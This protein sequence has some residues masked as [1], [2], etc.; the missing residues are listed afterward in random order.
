LAGQSSPRDLPAAS[1]SFCLFLRFFL[2]MNLTDEIDRGR[3]LFTG[4]L[5]YKDIQ[6]IQPVSRLLLRFQVV[7]LEFHSSSE[8]RRAALSR[9]GRDEP[10]DHKVLT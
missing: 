5:T 8:T 9:Q 2:E 10:R 1:A 6:R 3:L 7:C 4:I